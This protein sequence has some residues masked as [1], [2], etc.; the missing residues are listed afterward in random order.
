MKLVTFSVFTMFNQ[1]NIFVLTRNEKFYNLTYF[2][3]KMSVMM[4]S[5][6]ANM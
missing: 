4:T 5:S 1:V 6:V 2:Y 3:R